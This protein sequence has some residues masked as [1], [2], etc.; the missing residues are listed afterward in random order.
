MKNRSLRWQD[1]VT[2]IAG[3]WLFINPWIFGYSR[4]SYSWDAY[5]FGAVVFIFSIWAL[6][7]KRFWEEWVDL[8][9]GIWIF[10]S[11]WILGFS[12]NG[13]ALWNFLAVGFVLMVFAIWSLA[14]YPKSATPAHA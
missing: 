9:I 2:L 7:D 13:G 12:M 4:M 1:W 3:L 11:P 6:S 10:L 14:A 5:L 8:L